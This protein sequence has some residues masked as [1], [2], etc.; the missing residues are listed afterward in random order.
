MSTLPSL[1]SFLT[2]RFD[3]MASSAA[4]HVLSS[5][6]L[7]RYAALFQEGLHEDMLPF[8][9]WFVPDTNQTFD[10]L[11][12]A[13]DL[14]HPFWEPTFTTWY[15]QFEKSRLCLLFRLLPRMRQV[16]ALEAAVSGR[17]AVLQ[18]MLAEGLLD[19]LSVHWNNLAAVVF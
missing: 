18:Y 11:V 3:P 14:L 9:G 2:L 13:M 12:N 7:L 10:R 16:V 5:P 15:K 1:E 6:D 4:L 17:I 19:G 8:S